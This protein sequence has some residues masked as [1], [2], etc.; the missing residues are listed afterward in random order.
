MDTGQFDG[1]R[2]LSTLGA[3][4]RSYGHLLLLALLMAVMYLTRTVGYRKYLTEDGGVL[5]GND[6]W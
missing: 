1:R 2:L 6:P 3:H 4:L 5:R